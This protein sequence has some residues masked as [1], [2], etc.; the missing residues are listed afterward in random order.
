MAAVLCHQ[1]QHTASFSFSF[2]FFLFFLWSESLL[3]VFFFFLPFVVPR[4]LLFGK[5]N[6]GNIVGWVVAVCIDSIKN[7]SVS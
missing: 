3:Y 1:K 2:L 6:K 7:L 5:K 4:F